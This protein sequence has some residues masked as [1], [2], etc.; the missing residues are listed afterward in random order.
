MKSWLVGPVT[1]LSD[2]V[3]NAVLALAD[4]APDNSTPGLKLNPLHKRALDTVP[5]DICQYAVYFFM[6]TSQVGPSRSCSRSNHAVALI[7]Y[8][9]A[10]SGMLRC[11]VTSLGELL[12]FLGTPVM[13]NSPV[14]DHTLMYC[15]GLNKHLTTLRREWRNPLDTCLS[16]PNYFTLPST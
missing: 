1:T 14:W 11:A 10:T 2:V 5:D 6:A 12:L 8:V 16:C 3:T 15:T 13:F 7:N 9:T 4:A